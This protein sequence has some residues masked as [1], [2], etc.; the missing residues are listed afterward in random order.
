MNIP[1]ARVLPIVATVAVTLTV[2]FLTPLR[3][4]NIVEPTIYD[5]DPTEFQ[6][7]F[8]ANPDN[9]IFIDVR[10]ESA[11]SN[12]HAVGSRSMPVHTLYDERHVLPRRGKEI[13][14]ICSGGKASG[15]GYSYLEH[16]GF[17]NIARIEGGI[18][19]WIAAGL[20]VEGDNAS[21]Q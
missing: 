21:G 5:I 19:H 15:V 13:V 7:Q 8:E 16:F 11:Y 4:L 1:I 18:E 3:Y 2:F 14:L 10:P 6:A 17:R 12:L 9:Y 20:P